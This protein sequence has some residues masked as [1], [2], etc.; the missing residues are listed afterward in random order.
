M[1]ASWEES[2]IATMTRDQL[3]VF[4]KLHEAYGE[5]RRANVQLRTE[6]DEAVSMLGKSAVLI[7]ELN[8]EVERLRNL[9]AGAGMA[10]VGK[11]DAA[12]VLVAQ[13][14]IAQMLEEQS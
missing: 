12:D 2:V 13:D 7:T 8:E 4:G 9:A 11:P 10:L 5:V 3:I 6:N 14:L 1:S